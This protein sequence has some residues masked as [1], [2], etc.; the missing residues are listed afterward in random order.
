[1]QVQQGPGWRFGFD[2]ARQ[3]YSVLIGGHDWAAELREQEAAG[4]HRAAQRLRAQWLAIRDQLMPEEQI[5]L[6]MECGPIWAELEGTAQAV[7]LRFVLQ[8]EGPERAMEGG[9]SAEATQALLAVL[10][11][12]AQLQRW[13]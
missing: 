3:P 5:S 4:L 6:D 2:P 13:P 9:W 7:A 1:L 11:Q 12:A 10:A 8:P